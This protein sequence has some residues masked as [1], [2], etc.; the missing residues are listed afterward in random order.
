MGSFYGNVTLLDT[1][2]DA[3]AATID[4]SAFAAA[5]LGAVV[6]FLESDDEGTPPPS[7]GP[8]SAALGRVAVAVM[9]HDDDL[10]FV[11][12]HHDGDLIFTGAIPDPSLVFDD[13][14]PGEPF[15]PA[16]VVGAL[17]RGDVARVA[18]IATA[19]HVFASDCHQQL[20]EALGL[21]TLGVGWGYRY[22]VADPDGYDGPELTRL[23]T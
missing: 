3:V 23:P 19:D 14:D 17:G 5:D 4:R 10:L 22:L 9:V 20:F 11:E 21:P 1:D 12:V 18:A 15:D 16:A 6:V 13:G 8:L 7:A 2:L